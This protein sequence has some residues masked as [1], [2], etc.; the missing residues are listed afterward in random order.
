MQLSGAT[1][2]TDEFFDHPATFF[3]KYF[4]QPNIP[5]D[6]TVVLMS[7]DVEAEVGVYEWA[8]DM[9]RMY[10]EKVESNRMTGRNRGRF[11]D[12][13]IGRGLRT[14]QAKAEEM[15]RSNTARAGRFRPY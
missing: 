1:S 8:C 6:H 4:F 15:I 12:F 11:N 10:V 13:V 3:R 7:V 14:V 2:S 9:Y 5:H